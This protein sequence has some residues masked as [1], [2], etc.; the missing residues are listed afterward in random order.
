MVSSGIKQI[1]VMG[2]AAD[3]SLQKNV[4]ILCQEN[5]DDA[6]SINYAN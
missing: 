5:S 1:K 6:L 3:P 2:R 4:D